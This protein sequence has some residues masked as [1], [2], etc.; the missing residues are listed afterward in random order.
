V[1]RAAKGFARIHSHRLALTCRD[2]H[3]ER[4]GANHLALDSLVFDRRDH[5][6]RP[7]QVLLWKKILT[8]VKPTQ[9]LQFALLSVLAKCNLDRARETEIDFGVCARTSIS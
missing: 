2:P 5:R 4:R 6:A 7:P 8:W 1:W 9:R 3:V